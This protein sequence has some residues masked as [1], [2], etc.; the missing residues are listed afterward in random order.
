MH[1]HSQSYIFNQTI[2]SSNPISNTL[3]SIEHPRPTTLFRPTHPSSLP[4]SSPRA[5]HT[6]LPH[7]PCSLTGSSILSSRGTG[8]KNVIR[9]KLLQIYIISIDYYIFNRILERYFETKV[10]IPEGA[11]KGQHDL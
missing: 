4:Q 1:R 3:I 10:I 9:T 5:P 2:T 7:S 8:V 6:P 11:G